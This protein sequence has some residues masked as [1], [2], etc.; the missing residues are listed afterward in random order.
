MLEEMPFSSC[1]VLCRH[2]WIGTATCLWILH[3]KLGFKDFHLGWVLHVLSINW[4]RERVS[5]LKLLRIALIEQKASYFQRIT[6]GDKS[7]F[8]L[9]Y[10]RDSVCATSR[11]EPSQRIKQK[12]G[13]EK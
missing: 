3:D 2:F 13:T 7:W 1:T 9:Y 5:C 8:F 10:L 6:I 4:K 12:S 11:D